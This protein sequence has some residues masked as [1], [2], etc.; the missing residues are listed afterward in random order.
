MW[1]IDDESDESSPGP[2][3]SLRASCS[4]ARK[5][6]SVLAEIQSTESIFQKHKYSN[7]SR[8]WVLIFLMEQCR[9]Y[10]QIIY[11]QIK[12]SLFDGNKQFV[13]INIPDFHD[14]QL[15]DLLMKLWNCTLL[16]RYYSSFG[17]RLGIGLFPDR[18]TK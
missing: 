1:V 16:E 13:A 15:L 2:K 17:L 6:F 10:I 9:D 8:P 4:E 5:L 3:A 11:A 12:T 18:R 14:W 7:L